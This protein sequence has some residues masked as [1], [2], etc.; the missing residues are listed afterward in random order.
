MVTLHLYILG[1]KMRRD[2]EI[3]AAMLP[4]TGAFINMWD[5]SYKVVSITLEI[6][7]AGDPFYAA[8]IQPIG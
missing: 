1:T 4:Q 5:G 7:K 3:P 2:I 6:P 8:T